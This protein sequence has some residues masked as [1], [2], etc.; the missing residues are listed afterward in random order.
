MTDTDLYLEAL[1][2]L[3]MGGVLGALVSI[4]LYFALVA[5]ALRRGNNRRSPRR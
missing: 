5:P 4:V 2:S 3:L 1:A